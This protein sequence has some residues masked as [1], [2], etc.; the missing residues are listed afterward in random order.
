MPKKVE[1]PMKVLGKVPMN[2]TSGEELMSAK[3]SVSDKPKSRAGDPPKTKVL[4]SQ[5]RGQG[6]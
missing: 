2:E 4:G 1:H 3:G 5:P 6:G